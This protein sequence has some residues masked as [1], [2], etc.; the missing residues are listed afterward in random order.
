[1]DENESI[2]EEMSLDSVSCFLSFTLF[3]NNDL[4]FD[5]N[6]I[7]E[8]DVL[9]MAALINAILKTDFVKDNIEKMQTS[10]EEGKKL[11]LTMF[12][13]KKYITPLEVGGLNAS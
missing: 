4:H 12:K 7:K 11:L 5:C 8:D 2:E 6:W 9:K 13:S 10:D 3:D 1:M